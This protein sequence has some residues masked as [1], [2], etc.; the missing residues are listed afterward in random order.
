MGEIKYNRKLTITLMVGFL[1]YLLSVAITGLF[2]LSQF[3]TD[4][5]AGYTVGLHILILFETP[6]VVCALIAIF[7]PLKM[8]TYIACSIALFTSLI[9]FLVPNALTT[10][11]YAPEVAIYYAIPYLRFSS[12]IILILNFAFILYAY[13]FKN[14]SIKNYILISI[15]AT[16]LSIVLPLILTFSFNYGIYSTA[17]SNVIQPVATI[18]PITL[19][20]KEINSIIIHEDDSFTSKMKY[21]YLEEYKKGKKG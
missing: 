14:S 21:P 4:S 19:F 11:V 6:I 18:L 13:I 17:F 16:I 10:I 7:R 2:C 12:I 9:F 8:L 3:G 20:N 1:G 5:I 15:V